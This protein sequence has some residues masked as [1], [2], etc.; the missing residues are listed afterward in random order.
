[1][2]K[3]KRLKQQSFPLHS[4]PSMMIPLSPVSF[5]FAPE[6]WVAPASPSRQNLS[7]ESPNTFPQK[8]EDEHCCKEFFLALSSKREESAKN[9]PRSRAATDSRRD[10]S[11]VARGAREP[12]QPFSLPLSLYFA[13]PF[14]LSPCR[15]GG[16]GGDGGILRRPRANDK[17]KSS[18][19]KAFFRRCA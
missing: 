3:E 1:M 10:A 2:E 14:S 4:P 13:R 5:F 12:S 9:S 11:A 6:I 16:G 8:E 15:G 17:Q 19:L 18:F 7:R